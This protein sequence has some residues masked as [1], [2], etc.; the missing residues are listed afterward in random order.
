MMRHPFQSVKIRRT[1][2]HMGPSDFWP[3]CQNRPWE[4]TVSLSAAFKPI[5]GSTSSRARSRITQGS[6]EGCAEDRWQRIL[7][8]AS[9]A[10]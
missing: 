10:S 4:L 1:C 6:R 5:T 3:Q 7:V 9:R 2:A 8:T